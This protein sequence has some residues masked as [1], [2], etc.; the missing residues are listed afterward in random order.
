MAGNKGW[1]GAF[2]AL[3]CS[4]LLVVNGCAGKEETAAV[5]PEANRPVDPAAAAPGAPPGT[6][7][8]STTAAP[9]AT[10]AGGEVKTT[11]SGLKYVVIE[12]GTGPMPKA[13]QT[14]AVHYTGTLK[15]GTKFDSSRD[16]NE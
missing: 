9:A 2:W 16:R 12:E 8:S 10:G 3:G 6:T 11:A 1:I 13:G 7:A 5:P 4:A 15:D 14:V